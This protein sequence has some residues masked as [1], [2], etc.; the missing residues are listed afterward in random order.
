MKNILTTL[1]LFFAVQLIAQTNQTNDLPT[2]SV[3]KNSIHFLSP[4]PVQYV[5][6]SSPHFAGDM[7]VNNIVRLKY[8]PDTAGNVE[9]EKSAIV[10]IVAQS[11]Y[12]QYNVVFEDR[13]IQAVTS[14]EVL[15]DHMRALEFP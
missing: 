6:I 8:H 7:P 10:T 15:P 4:E 3:T 5:D 14:V 2:I 13:P 9:P 12:A 11:Y 1:L